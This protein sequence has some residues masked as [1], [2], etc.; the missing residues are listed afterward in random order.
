MLIPAAVLVNRMVL[1]HCPA[2][3]TGHCPD[4]FGCRFH[5]LEFLPMQRQY[6]HIHN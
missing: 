4:V 1:K 6:S 2:H 3:V 5:T